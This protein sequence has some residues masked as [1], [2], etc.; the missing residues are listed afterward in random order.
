[1]TISI[2]INSIIAAAAMLTLTLTCIWRHLDNEASV[3]TYV[4]CVESIMYLVI[5]ND[6]NRAAVIENVIIN[7]CNVCGVD[8][9]SALKQERTTLEPKGKL[10][11]RIGKTPI[12]NG[13]IELQGEI[14]YKSSNTGI[15][16]KKHKINI[17]FGESK[18]RITSYSSEDS[19]AYMVTR[20]SGI[21]KT[22]KYMERA[23]NGECTVKQKIVVITIRNAGP[24]IILEDSIIKLTIQ[25]KSISES[26]EV[27]TYDSEAKE[28]DTTNNREAYIDIVFQ[29]S[30]NHNINID[31]MTGI[32][33]GFGSDYSIKR[34][35]KC[36]DIM[37]NIHTGITTELKVEIEV[38]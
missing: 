27:T 30:S 9:K 37:Y 4:H 24:Y 2:I 19:L 6:G 31:N 33:L 36:E 28:A 15:F 13:G 16:T 1:M 5:L 17:I 20:L 34:V 7:K 22:L 14:R 11:Y 3:V 23:L 21:D 25:D 12:R 35:I 8:K 10:F 38:I 29:R 18:A 26:K 32:S